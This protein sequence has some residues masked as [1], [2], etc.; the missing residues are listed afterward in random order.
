VGDQSSAKA[1]TYTEKNTS[2]PGAEFE[3]AIPMFERP[4][5]VLALDRV[6][7]ETGKRERH[8]AEIENITHIIDSSSHSEL[9]RDLNQGSG[10]FVLG[11]D[12]CNR[13]WKWTVVFFRLSHSSL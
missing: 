2:M 8:D 4:K 1:S 12:R 10:I 3:S 6:A 13:M 5:T 7:I 9:L 11:A